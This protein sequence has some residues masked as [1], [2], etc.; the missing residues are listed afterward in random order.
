MKAFMMQAAKECAAVG[1][2]LS[3]L[4]LAIENVFRV[5]TCEKKTN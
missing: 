2:S 5:D 3:N 4:Q 1:A